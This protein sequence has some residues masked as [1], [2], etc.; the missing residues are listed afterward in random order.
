MPE[1]DP[2]ETIVRSLLAT[3][4][5]KL[6]EEQ[7]AGFVRVYPTLRA[8]ADSLYAIPEVRYEEPAVTFRAKT[9]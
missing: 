8:Q 9:D 2:A 1:S 4:G 3:A 6:T 7:I 5:L